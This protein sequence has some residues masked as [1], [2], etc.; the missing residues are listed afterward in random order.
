MDLESAAHDQVSPLDLTARPQ[1]AFR[2]SL[3]L[4]V[5]DVQALWTAAAAKM[6]CASGMTL[7]DVL[8]VIGPRE[9]PSISECVAAI[10]NPAVL[11]GCVLDD[12][13]IDGL[14]VR[15]PRIEGA[16]LGPEQRPVSGES[17]SRRPSAALRPRAK[18]RLCTIPPVATVS[19]IN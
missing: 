12:F 11:P 6:L 19:P 10:A 7:D 9:D 8:D 15:S 4:A 14:R 2:I 5:S 16:A 3:T 18:L 13:W 1:P 17:P